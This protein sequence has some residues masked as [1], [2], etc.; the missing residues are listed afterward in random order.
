MSINYLQWCPLLRD[1]T[2]ESDIIMKSHISPQSIRYFGADILP[3]DVFKGLSQPNT[4]II[5]QLN[6]LTFAKACLLKKS[7]IIKSHFIGEK[8][9]GVISLRKFYSRKNL[10]TWV[11]FSHFSSTNFSDQSLLPDFLLCFFKNIIE[12]YF[13][14]SEDR[15]R[16]QFTTQNT[17]LELLIVIRRSINREKNLEKVLV[18]D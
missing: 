13:P 16:K 1:F 7:L 6:F 15:L 14:F 10:V 2:A 3:S 17:M 11:H 9:I 8:K 18:G 12:K 4:R 5:Y